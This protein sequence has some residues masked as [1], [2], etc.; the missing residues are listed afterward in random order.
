MNSARTT[1]HEMHP[2]IKL[3]PTAGSAHLVLHLILFLSFFSQSWAQ[4]PLRQIKGTVLDQSGAVVPKV[5]IEV[6][7]PSGQIAATG[8][9]DRQGRFT[10]EVPD[11]NYELDA[12]VPGLA[13]VRKMPLD[14]GAASVPIRLTLEVASI[15]EA[16]IVTATRSETPVAQVGSS[17]SIIPGD[18]LQQQGILSVA[19]ALRR[20]PGLAVSQSGGAGQVTSLFLR[21]GESDYT[22]VLIDGIPVNEPGGSVNFANLPATAIE[23]IEIVRGP[24]SALFGSDAMAGVIQ[25]I[26]KRGSSEGLEPRPGISFEGGSF[27]TFRYQAGIGGKDERFDYA[28]SFARLDTDNNVSNG[29][30]NDAVVSV[31]VGVHP[32]KKSSLRLIF[33]SDAGRAGVPGQWAFHRPD[34]DQYYRHRTVAGGITFTHLT[35][36]RWTQTFTFSSQDLRQFSEDRGLSGSYYS[37]YGGV[38]APYPSY[39]YAYQTLNQSRRQKVGYLTELALPHAHFLT[40]GVE[41]ERESGVVGDPRSDPLEATRNNAGAFIQD[42]WALHKS[43]FIA[44]GVRLEHNSSFGY[45][46]T[47][48]ISAAWLLRQ[49]ADGVLGM[50]K[51]KANFGLGI[52]EPTL[53]ESFSKSPFFLGNPDLEPEKSTSYDIGFEQNFGG[54]KGLFSLTYYENRFRNQIDFVTTDYTTYAGTFFNTGKTR[55]RGLETGFQ[56]NLLPSLTLAASYTFTDSLV[57]ENPAAFDPVFAPGQPLLRRP[58]HSG[59]LDLR[60]KPGRWTFAATSTLVGSRADSDFSG[61]GIGRNPAYGVLDLSASFRL[62]TGAALY[63]AV[64]NVLDRSY[65]EVLGYPA[66]PARFRLGITTGF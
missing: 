35:T 34:A 63:L 29:S 11:G 6:R 15:R 21:G 22:K 2:H 26:T 32:W 16:I 39:D 59:Y 58:R 36:S 49:G 31:N 27:A 47:P 55:A 52:K 1:T 46:A 60:W 3:P 54:G 56:R 10:I 5:Q 64:N 30:Y 57:L 37:S 4:E 42:Q 62:F 18:D 51:I 48:R 23:R 13:P 7:N 9:T 53:V 45:A 8:W 61:L 24:Q 41:Y 40:A 33:R 17:T 25:I 12:S 43:L 28:A 50:T 20:L 38:T 14:V 44:A 19:D 66:L 65:M